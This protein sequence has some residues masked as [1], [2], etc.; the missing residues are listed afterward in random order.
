MPPV[1]LQNFTKMYE[2]TVALHKCITIKCKKEEEESEQSNKSKYIVEKEKLM[3]EF[4]KKME[5]ENE[6]YK[7]DRKK[8]DKNKK[9]RVR[10]DIEFGEYYMKHI[11]A[12][13]DLDI[14]I[15]EERYHNELFNCRLK[16]CYNES[17]LL[18]N[19]TIENI[20]TSTGENTELYKLASKYKT[21]FETN[22]L[23]GKDI[24][25]FEIDKRKVELASNLAKLQTDMIKL[26]KK[27]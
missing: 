27:L 18:L 12:N 17:L 21:I 13:A 24:N 16:G 11:K 4:S 23:T 3:L 1:F 25:A 10:G 6:R 8:K 2:A 7:K 9:D 15:I 19:L 5:G 14:K 26:K 20:L 22:K